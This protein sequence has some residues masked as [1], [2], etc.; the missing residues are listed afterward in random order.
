MEMKFNWEI[1]SRKREF[2]IASIEILRNEWMI[3]CSRDGEFAV[4]FEKLSILNSLLL[5]YSC[6]VS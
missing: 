6:A 1:F 2:F 3:T 4:W 5:F